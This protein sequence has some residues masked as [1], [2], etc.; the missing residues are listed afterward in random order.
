ML[1]FEGT[2]K[3][4]SRS[5]ASQSSSMKSLCLD[6][7]TTDG[8]VSFIRALIFQQQCSFERATALTSRQKGRI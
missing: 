3:L 5:P 4:S 7:S 1:D 2:L 6:T 8:F